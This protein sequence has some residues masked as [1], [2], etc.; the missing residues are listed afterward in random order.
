MDSSENNNQFRSVRL[1]QRGDMARLGAVMP[2]ESSVDATRRSRSSRR[3][4]RETERRSRD[5]RRESRRGRSARRADD[6]R[7]FAWE[8]SASGERASNRPP[9]EHV[10]AYLDESSV[11]RVTRRS[12]RSRSYEAVEELERPRRAPE[13][14]PK[15]KRGFTLVPKRAERASAQHDAWQDDSA[16]VEETWQ[17]QP[18]R[19]ERRRNTFVDDYDYDSQGISG[20]LSRRQAVIDALRIVPEAIGNA[21]L[22]ALGLVRM[23]G[24]MVVL[25]IA[26][27]VTMLFA[28]LRD[29][30]LANRRLDTL[31]A[32]Y[33]AL[34]AENDEIRSELE[35]LQTREGIE[36][37]ARAR[38]YVL[39]GETKVVVEGIETN[40]KTQLATVMDEVELPDERPWYIKTLDD[41]FGYDP[42]A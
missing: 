38:G 39:P 23:K 34:L 1:I 10:S 4:E 15:P 22:G 20:S 29:L 19:A 27:V 35:T 36:N 6:G 9:R 40:E 7:G 30:Y 33:D 5:D 28:P 42:E 3:D 16:H 26:L 2:A 32:T 41:L 37:E 24:I 11:V 8:Q 14:K 25:A 12:D 31:Q 17:E 21:V 13:S 18:R